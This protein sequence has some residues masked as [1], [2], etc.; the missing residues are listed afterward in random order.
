MGLDF[1][2]TKL[3]A[4]LVTFAEDQRDG[5]LS[6]YDLRSALEANEDLNAHLK[7][8]EHRF[9]T[10]L[11]EMSNKDLILT[12]ARNTNAQLEQELKT[13]AAENAELKAQLAEAK[14]A[15]HKVTEQLVQSQARE[16]SSY[17][18]GAADGQRHFLASPTG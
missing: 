9:E 2:Y 3:C 12:A 1:W 17:E 5:S 15:S 16:S 18:H 11:Q 6:S 7:D 8:K 4:T 13:R 14:V 10:T